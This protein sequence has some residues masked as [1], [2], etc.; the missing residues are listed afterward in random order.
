[1]YLDVCSGSLGNREL[2]V[3]LWRDTAGASMVLAV[4][5]HIGCIGGQQIVN[6][7]VCVA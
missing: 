2:L 1:M 6:I 5:S 7:D 4:S 3:D